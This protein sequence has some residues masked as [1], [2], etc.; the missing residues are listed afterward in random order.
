MSRTFDFSDEF[1]DNL[2]SVLVLDENF[3]FYK[4]R[5]EHDGVVYVEKC[6]VRKGRYIPSELTNQSGFPY[7]KPNR[8]DAFLVKE[9]NFERHYATIPTTWFDYQQVS[10]RALW[11]GTINYVSEAGGGD[12]WSKT[13][14][15]SAKATHYY[16]NKNQLPTIPVPFQDED[17]G[18]TYVN[19]FSRIY[20]TAPRSSLGRNWEDQIGSQG[21][22]VAI[23]PDR[24]TPYM[25]DIYELI[26]FTF[27]F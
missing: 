6:L 10:Y 2:N 7:A 18:Q 1:L 13:R 19:D 24:I 9:T 4:P 20:T 14:I 8:S 25:G 16:F 5:M 27:I 21:I 23:A 26:R 3:N 17:N 15:T 22:L 12:S 11:D